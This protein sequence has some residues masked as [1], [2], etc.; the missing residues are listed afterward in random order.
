MTVPKPLPRCRVRKASNSAVKAAKPTSKQIKRKPAPAKAATCNAPVAKMWIDPQLDDNCMDVS[1]GS[2][3]TVLAD[4][5]SSTE[6]V[7]PDASCPEPTLCKTRTFNHGLPSFDPPLPED[8]RTPSVQ[9]EFIPP[10]SNLGP[11]PPI[12]C[13]QPNPVECSVTPSEV[14]RPVPLRDQCHF[15][16]SSM[17]S[18]PRRQVGPGQNDFNST[19][20]PRVANPMRP[21]PMFTHS[22]PPR[23]MAPKVEHVRHPGFASSSTG[24]AGYF[25]GG[26]GYSSRQTGED[27]WTTQAEPSMYTATGDPSALLLSP[28]TCSFSSGYSEATFAQLDTWTDGIQTMQS[29]H[30]SLDDPRQHFGQQ[31]VAVPR[32]QGYSMDNAPPAGHPNSADQSTCPMAF[33]NHTS[34]GNINSFGQFPHG[35]L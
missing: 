30:Q 7:A 12:I 13:T 6:E 29:Y 19:A 20:A 2:E 10:L 1:D 24:F 22:P 17:Q 34:L 21:R 9:E 23:P 33:Y 26:A 5:P 28:T 25:P 14:Q 31:A 8:Q 15:G 35:Q 27:P 4:T 11:D 16:S 3:P 32:Y 18:F